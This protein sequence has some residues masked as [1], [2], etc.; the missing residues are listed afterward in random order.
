M[1]TSPDLEFQDISPNLPLP[2][3]SWPNIDDIV[4]YA[5]RAYR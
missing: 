5:Y 4:A 2:P 3:E 1:T